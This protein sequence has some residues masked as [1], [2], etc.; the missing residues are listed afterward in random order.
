MDADKS[1]PV[2]RPLAA[3]AKRAPVRRPRNLA[4][5]ELDAGP[6]RDVRD[7]L[8]DLHE[9]AGRPAL[10]ELEKQ[11][12]GDDR[13]NGSPK[14]DMIHRIISRGGP[15]DLDDVRAVARTL[16][17]ACGR[18]EHTVDAQVTLW[19]RAPQ[20]P[21]MPGPL[22]APRSAYLAQV[23]QIAPPELVGREAELA[24]LARFCLDEQAG[25]Y[26]WWQAGP[27]AG[28][29]ALLSTFVLDP[30]EAVRSRVQVV[31]FF[32]T[33]RQ[34][35][36]DT[37]AAFT[38]VVG[39][40]LAALTGQQVPAVIDE[41][42][43]EA[44][45]LDLL[46]Q[47][48]QGCRQRGM[49]LVLLVDGLDEDRGVT[50]GPHARSIAA[51]LPGVAPA[52]MRVIVAGRPNP[53]VPDDV[54]DWHPLRQPGIIRPLADSPHARDL[55]RLGQTELKRLLTGSPIEHDLL[56][57]LTA[58]RGGLS[59]E[60]LCE[61]T[62]AGLVEI[63]EVLHTVAGR[64]FTRRLQQWS[65]A[66]GP[67]VYLLGHEELDAAARRYLRETRLTG[68]RNRL[69]EWAGRY[70]RP[71]HGSPRWP[72]G[73]P[74]YL[75]LGYPRM[76][77]T[78]GEVSRLVDLVTDPDR[79]DRMLDLT[80]GD[81]AAL[82]EITTCQDLVLARPEPDLEAMLR[83]CIRR[84]NL[85]DRNSNIPPG[86]PAVWAA[87]HQPAR[88]EALA[89]SITDPYQQVQAL[90]AVAGA[91]AGADPGRARQLAARAETVARSITSPGL[92]AQALTAVVRTV[93]GTDSDR[94]R[95]LAGR[96][97]TVARS[98]TDPGLQAQAL[99]EVAGA[100][101]G[102][103]P[104]R[105]ETVARSIT[106]PG[107]QAHAL[108]EVA[109]AVAGADPDRAETVA[110]SITDPGL[111]ARALTAVVQAVAGTDPGRAR[112]LAA[113][114]ETVARSITD[115]GQQAH[116]LAEVAGAVA[117]ADPD[118]A[119]TVA[120][121][122]TDPYQQAQAL[123]AVAGAVAGT[124]PGR[125]R[126]LAARAETVA[127]SITDPYQQARALAAVVQA[128]AGTDPG[129]ARQLAAR[130]ETVA[131][132]ITDPYQQA[133]ALAAVVQ[134]VAGTDPGR[135]RQLAAR[136][137]PWPAPSP[138]RTSRRGRW[139]RW[140]RRSPVPIPAGPGNSPPGPRPW[141][142]PSP[143]RTSRRGRWPR[144]FR[145]SPVPIPAGPGNSPP[146]PRP[147]PAPS[148]TQAGRRT[149]WPQWPERSPAPIPAG[150]GNSPPGPR[151]WPA[152]SPTRTSR[153][154]RRPRW[155]RRSPAPIPTGP[156]PWPA[157]S[158]TLTGRRRR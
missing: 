150:P 31:A 126:Q 146:G 147:R 16:A 139:P 90:T 119:E 110:R 28:K 125:A 102:A 79:H 82:A 140:F 50:T 151:P 32:I 72:Q 134:A 71:G 37:R 34:A 4:R 3:A 121:S 52:G 21:A 44:W 138:T 100:V 137:E 49:R 14:K 24:E 84:T 130:A 65:A 107:W 6:Q 19:M 105:A 67:V 51:L 8:Y 20:R 92:Q 135:A 153:R 77:A 78:A 95:Q 48:A 54:P 11:I 122:I 2:R 81:A 1:R 46:E 157:P 104:A 141:P 22:L 88:A 103:D 98:I 13:L 131:R 118:R 106:D 120:R 7:L 89:R 94:V 64:T 87:L 99:A 133:R 145:R 154:R 156:K 42:L 109:G 76:L 69:H 136:A 114:A 129:R 85:A 144:W 5:P 148:P 74:E 101:A 45:L 30:P 27:W 152:P 61:L 127:R 25:A 58:A 132:S 26:V 97:E 41:S 39:E 10:E 53:P 149:R 124:D 9:K 75:L 117:G 96:A 57:L 83:L 55:Q 15:A 47:A 40:Q 143:T 29:S 93:A 33:A 68:Y 158:P 66:D 62:G 142:A 56:G 86:L 113:R 18:D 115:P 112:Q 123:T 12:A 59:G 60:D 35:A 63:E 155:F 38:A 43:R 73:T 23:R 17:R 116:A 80:G 111:Q 108:A 91:V 70:R 36:Q 128:V